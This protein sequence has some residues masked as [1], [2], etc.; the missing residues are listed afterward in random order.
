MDNIGGFSKI[1]IIP[2]SSIESIGVAANKAILVLRRN[3]SWTP[4]VTQESISVAHDVEQSSALTVNSQVASVRIPNFLLE[5]KDKCIALALAGRQ[6]VAIVTS[7]NG[8][9]WLLGSKLC[10][11]IFKT[12]QLMPGEA[13][14]YTGLEL[15]LSCTSSLSILE[16]VVD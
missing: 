6:C 14:G 1:E 16:L 3:I 15:N 13:S 9:A 7:T 4:Q 8:T 5:E 2:T 12:K 11:L 10:P